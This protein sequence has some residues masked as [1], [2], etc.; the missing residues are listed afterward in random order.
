MN[1]F[2]KLAEPHLIFLI[3]IFLVVSYKI[4]ISLLKATKNNTFDEVVKKATKNPGGY[5]DE[6]IISSVF[7]EWWT[8]IISPVEE[9]LAKSRI[10]PNFLTFMSFTISF[11][12]CY[13]YAADWIFLGSLVLLAG[14]SFDILD[15]RVARINNVTSTKGA[16]LDSCLDRFSEIVVMFGLLIKFSSSVFVYV[17][18]LATVFSLTVSY[19][20]SAADN[21]GFDSNIGLMQRPERVVCLGLGGLI[22]GCLEF[23][24]VQ[25]LGINHS[26]LMFTIV[27]IAVL[28]LIATLQR[29]FKAMNN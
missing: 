28:S 10:N 1:N 6:T 2:L 16:F 18:F 9:N 5:S 3:I 19:V 12:T 11:L 24:D 29:F 23:Y 8:F 15:G 22:S 26:I 25:I 21:H 13:L 27:F 7:K 20:K 14:S 17:V 4:V